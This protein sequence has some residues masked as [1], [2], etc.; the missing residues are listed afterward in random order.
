M[1]VRREEKSIHLIGFR[2]FLLLSIFILISLLQCSGSRSVVIIKAAGYLPDAEKPEGDDAITRATSKDNNTHTFAERLQ[3][4]LLAQKM[5]VRIIDYTEAKGQTFV[6]DL[7][8][9]AGPT[10]GGKLIKQILNLNKEITIGPK[11][12]CTCLTPCGTPSS[13]DKAAEHMNQYLADAGLEVIPG[14][15]IGAKIPADSINIAINK[16]TERLVE[17]L[18]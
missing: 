13:G 16:F 14:M 10:W 15:A 3:E 7:V 12:V 11:T 17:G 8:I 18:K 6:D 9:F 5:I 2:L 1:R 4:K